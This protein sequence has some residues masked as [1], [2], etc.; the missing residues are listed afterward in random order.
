V[1]EVFP[2]KAMGSMK[3]QLKIDQVG[4]CA[5]CVHA[6]VIGN[7]RGSLFYFCS[8][9]KI[10]PE[11]AKYPRLPVLRCSGFQPANPDISPPGA[12]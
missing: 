9:S 3:S 7:A 2:A 6:R 11:Y 1:E 5:N 10:N 12:A 8:L 4:L